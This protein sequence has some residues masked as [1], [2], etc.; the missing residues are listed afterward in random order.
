MKKFFFVILACLSSFAGLKAQ[1]IKPFVADDRVVFL[2]NSIT[3]GGHYHS[4]IWL[5]YMTR[6]PNMPL[7]VF[8]GGIGGDTVYDMYKRLDGDIFSKNPN[9]IFVTFGMNDTGYYEYN[10]DNAE[11]FAEKKYNECIKNFKDLELRLLGLDNVR[12]VMAGTSPYDEFAKIKDNEPFRRKNE[13]IKRVVA[14]QKEAAKRNG[15]EFID[16]NRPM[17]DL[18]LQNQK[19]DSTFS[20]CGTDR[21][22]PDND[23]HMVMAYLLLKEQGF[24]NVPVAKFKINAKKSVVEESQNCQITN[25]RKNGNE[26]RFDYK[27]E[28]LPYPLDTIARNW[29]AQ[30]SQALALKVIPFIEEMN[31]EVIQVDGLKGNYTIYIDDENIGEWSAEDFKKGINLAEQ[32]KTPQ[33]QQALAVMHLNEMRYEIERQFREFAW[34]Q[35]GF[36]QQHGLANANNRKAIEVLDANADKNGWLKARRDLYA[37]LMLPEV[38]QQRV[39]EMNSFVSKIY[40]INKPKTRRVILRKNDGK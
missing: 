18:N 28:A 3:D 4:Y 21:I 24:E 10:G 6:F 11:E 23:G 33:Y 35:Y 15:W 40:E 8:N 22:H 16:W 14:Y 20:L 9:V 5:Y 32:T 26:I 36:F 19:A 7:M 27:A 30:K 1:T 29:G 38:Y 2:G 17:V 25:V 39:D 34:C 37:K 13:N 12:I 31:Q